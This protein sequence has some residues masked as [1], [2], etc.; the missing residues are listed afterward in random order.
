MNPFTNLRLQPSFGHSKVV[1]AWDTP[2]A[3]TGGKYF[4]YRSPSGVKGTWELLN[5]HAPVK[6][7]VSHWEDSS[8]QLPPPGSTLYYRVL[9]VAPDNTGTDSPVV[10]LWNRLPR[11]EYGLVR[12]AM[13]EEF[14]Q[15]RAG[16]GI[17][18]F[19]CI[20]LASG[21]LAANIDPETLQ[22][23]SVPCPDSTSYGQLFEGGFA[24]PVQTWTKIQAIQLDRDDR[25]DG[26]GVT[27]RFDV[28][29]RLLA[30][31]P[32]RPGHMIACPR[33]DDRWVIGP[34]IVP[35]RHRGVVPVA[36]DAPAT[37]LRSTDERYKYPLPELVPVFP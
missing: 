11:E 30:V 34:G 25:D 31:P 12:M 10:D 36:W 27:E 8:A 3:C 29:L 1:V 15:M 20:P 23:S 18:V 19:H 13:L 14:N 2:E 21:M 4:V 28:R 35:Y 24:P 9:Y 7:G 5:E 33:T 17:P 32:P 16:G 26:L 22:P 6:H 37:R